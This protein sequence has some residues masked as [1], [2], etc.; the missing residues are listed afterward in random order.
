[1]SRI[2]GL[3]KAIAGVFCA[4]VLFADG[5][6]V[7]AAPWKVTSREPAVN[8]S[9]GASWLRFTVSGEEAVDFQVVC[10]SATRCTLRVVDQPARSSAGSLGAAM[11]R[12]N[13]VAGINGGFFSPAFEPLGLVI[14]QGFRAGAWQRSS[15]LGG[16]LA[17][18]KDRLM[19]LWRDEFQ[20]GPGVTELLQA[21]PRLV[22]HGTAITGLET[23]RSRPR[24]FIATDNAGR[25]LIGIAQ[26]TTLQHLAQILA[27]PGLVP[28]LEIDRALNFD[29]GKSTGLWL[30]TKAGEI[31]YESEISTVRNFVA[32]VSKD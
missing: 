25:W 31:K 7:A 23:G 11:K 10:F 29:G 26:Y 4:S 19:L 2:A 9:A 13:A 17:V 14:S 1:M 15:L 30:R 20:D 22:N 21:G 6:V 18:R 28:G 16:L 27:T 8:L 12:V 3:V 32:V 24:S 5:P